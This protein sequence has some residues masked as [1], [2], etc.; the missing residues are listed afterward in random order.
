[1]QQAFPLSVPL[2]LAPFT[3]PGLPARLQRGFQ[4]GRRDFSSSPGTLPFSPNSR[5]EKGSWRP[6]TYLL[7]TQGKE[8]PALL[9]RGG[10]F[11]GSQGILLDLRSR[12]C[13]NRD[14]RTVWKDRR[15]AGGPCCNGSLEGKM[16]SSFPQSSCLLA[17]YNGGDKASFVRHCHPEWTGRTLLCLHCV[18]VRPLA[19]PRLSIN[20]GGR[21]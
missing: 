21:N 20:G 6:Y 15:R 13:V 7:R 3:F 19:A 2:A 10:A 4:F 16:P 5:G 17:H 18:P 1:M 9:L 14:K 12:T 11:F 8:W